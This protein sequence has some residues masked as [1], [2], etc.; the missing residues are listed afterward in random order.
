MTNIEVIVKKG[1]KT[2]EINE[3][4]LALDDSFFGAETGEVKN[5]SEKYLSLK[6]QNKDLDFATDEHLKVHQFI[7]YQSLDNYIQVH[8]W[9]GENDPTTITLTGNFNAHISE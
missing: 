9:T 1:D 8:N 5:T 3:S 4:S 6:Y 7:D 2:L